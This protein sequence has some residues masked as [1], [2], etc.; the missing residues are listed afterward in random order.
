MIGNI[1]G[2]KKYS[3]YVPNGWWEKEITTVAWENGKIQGYNTNPEEKWNSILTVIQFVNHYL[4]L[5]IGILC[6]IFILWNGFNLITK[7]GADEWKKALNAII[8]SL[9]GIVICIVAYGIVNVVVNYF[10]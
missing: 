3:L 1:G 7:P 4:R 9:V 10:Q 6:F 2:A 5:S 8:G